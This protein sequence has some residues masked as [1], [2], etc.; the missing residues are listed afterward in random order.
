M[1]FPNPT[2]AT[3]TVRLPATLTLRPGSLTVHNAHGRRLQVRLQ[4]ATN[5]DSQFSTTGWANGVYW[6]Q[7]ETTNGQTMQQKLV[8]Q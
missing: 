2:A 8:K 6:L 3:V 5:A 7:L 1:A 4:P